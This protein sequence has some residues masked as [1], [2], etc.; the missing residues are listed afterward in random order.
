MYAVSISMN[1]AC[2]MFTL[3]GFI[4]LG[5]TLFVTLAVVLMRFICFIYNSKLLINVGECVATYKQPLI[6]T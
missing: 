1:T 3:F 6:Y 2:K 4:W 5:K